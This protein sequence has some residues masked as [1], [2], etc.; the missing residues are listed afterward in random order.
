M[1]YKVDTL[2]PEDA[3]FVT[4]YLGFRVEP[5]IN[6]LFRQVVQDMIEGKEV[7]IDVRYRSLNIHRNAGD[8]RFVL[9]KRFVSYDNDL[10]NFQRLIMTAYLSLKR[11]A[12]STKE[13]YGLDTSNVVTEAIP[14]VIR[15][16]KHLPMD[17]L[18]S[19]LDHSLPDNQYTDK[20]SD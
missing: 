13:A 8:F 20:H 3:Y 4:F 2:A 11:I 9:F 15:T 17:R 12:L 7:T 6:F 16:P 5:R 1:Q 19:D 18:P 14:L 10:T